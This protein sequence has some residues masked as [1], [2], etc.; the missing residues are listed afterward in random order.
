KIVQGSIIFDGADVLKM[1][2]D[3]VRGI[4]GNNIAMIFQDP[5]TSLNPVLT[6]SRQI[7]EA[8]ELHLKMDKAE[9]RKRT[10][11]LLDL[12]GIPS[13]PR[14]RPPYKSSPNRPC[15][16]RR[17]SFDPPRA[18]TSGASPSAFRSRAFRLTSSR[19]RQVA[20]SSRAASTGATS[21]ARRSPRSNASRTPSR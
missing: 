8:L 9:A 4:R 10:V 5:M 17:A 15:P 14:A 19:R 11:E 3:E 16:T 20:D 6:I 7:T 13:A 1:D 2:D 18:S 21:L 12:V